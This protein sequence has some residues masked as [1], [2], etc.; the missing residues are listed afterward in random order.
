MGDADLDGTPLQMME[1]TLRVDVKGTR[2]AQLSMNRRILI[3]IFKD[4]G[5]L[6]VWS[7]ERQNVWY[8]TFEDSQTVS[9]YDGQS[10]NSKSVGLILLFAACDKIVVKARVHWLP[11]W[12]TN[13]EVLR[14][15]GTR[16][17]IKS[18]TH[19]MDGGIAT[20]VREVIYSM[21]EGEQRFLPYFTSVHGHRCLLS[22]PGRPPICFRCEE[23]GHLRHQCQGGSMP[24]SGPRSYA[25]AVQTPAV[26]KRAE[27][28]V[29]K[30]PPPQAAS[31][32]SEGLTGPACR[33]GDSHGP[34]EGPA[35]AT[36]DPPN[37]NQEDHEGPA[38]GGV[39]VSPSPVIILQGDT[40]VP[41]SE[42]AVSL[43]C[44]QETHE[45]QVVEDTRSVS[46]PQDIDMVEE[47]GLE[48]SRD[49]EVS[50]QWGDTEVSLTDDE[51]EYTV[52]K[53]RKR[54]DPI[55]PSAAQPSRADR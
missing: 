46:S 37:D 5:V 31:K 39:P 55:S 12:V 38:E 20:G 10:L 7:M 8:V 30:A 21:R 14:V 34:Q 25:T 33:S 50:L 3:D 18:I 11:I 17:D 19:M 52:V 4:R 47:L 24:Q 27:G 22:V 28:P 35:N 53:R 45:S 32:S 36:A 51:V 15:L 9:E 23:V 40:E 26:G 41:P 2:A 43:Q 1:R 13:E 16:E 29:G 54:D 48:L 6:A 44:G 49:T 42:E